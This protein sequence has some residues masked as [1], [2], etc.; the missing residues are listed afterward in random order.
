MTVEK[1]VAQT[2]FVVMVVMLTDVSQGMVGCYWIA[3]SALGRKAPSELP[4]DLM[5]GFQ[6]LDRGTV[7]P[8]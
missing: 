8:E 7:G 4:G 2:A 1:A 5:R 6:R 3:L